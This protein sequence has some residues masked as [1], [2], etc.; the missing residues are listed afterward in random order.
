M[1]QT[2]TKRSSDGI[3][4]ISLINAWNIE[5]LQLLR[6]GTTEM[7]WSRL[8]TH[9]VSWSRHYAHAGALIAVRG[10][11]PRQHPFGQRFGVSRTCV[12]GSDS[13]FLGMLTQ[14]A[15]VGWLLSPSRCLEER[16]RWVSE[17]SQRTSGAAG[18]FRVSSSHLS[19]SNLKCH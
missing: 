14:K 3:G 1:S 12:F 19:N 7:V 17:I 13:S 11:S 15:S 2:F 10:H 6:C 4:F 5:R 18:V 9:C 8:E 16:R